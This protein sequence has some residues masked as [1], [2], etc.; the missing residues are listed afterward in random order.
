MTKK[1][2]IRQ[3]SS[4]KWL[5][6]VVIVLIIFG[7]GFVLKPIISSWII[8]AQNH[9][10]Q[11]GN[12]T[13]TFFNRILFSDA[14]LKQNELLKVNNQELTF[15]LS[16]SENIK[17]ENEELRKILDLELHKDFEFIDAY[18]YAKDINT[19]S[20]YINKGEKD[21][22]KIDS[23]I[24]NSQ[25]VLIGK[26]AKTF[27]NYSLV[28]LITST[29]IKTNVEIGDS[30][31]EAIAKGKGNLEMMVENIPQDEEI[32]SGDVVVTGNLQN[33]Y[34]RGLPLGTVKYVKLTDLDPF[35][36]AVISPYIDL[37]SL[38]L[39]LVIPDF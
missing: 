11:S 18:V 13:Y 33:E 3:N 15:K 4:R 7:L 26:V 8:S 39:V 27:S 34:P 6:S 25:K 37:N 17:A 29:Q 12:N 14:I 36:T 31:I 21:G 22:V 38:G 9:F 28:S 35:Q 32:K 30:R 24:L 16:Q 2:K 20:V 23:V 1:I 19:D 5:V 10:Y